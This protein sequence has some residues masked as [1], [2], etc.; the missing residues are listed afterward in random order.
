MARAIKRLYEI[1]GIEHGGA[2]DHGDTLETIATE[3]RKSIA[4]VKRLRTLAD[5]IPE[6]S[7]MM[8]AGPDKPDPGA[9]LQPGEE[10]GAW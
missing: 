3:T 10:G 6:L 9:N 1:W 8:D 5:L 2:R 4:T 7:A